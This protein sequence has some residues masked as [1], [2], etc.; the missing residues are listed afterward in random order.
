MECQFHTFHPRSSRPP[1]YP[2]PPDANNGC[3]GTHPG[4]TIT[5]I[6]S[7]IVNTIKK[8]SNKSRDR[9]L[10]FRQILQLSV[11]V[12]AAMQAMATNGGTTR[13]RISSSI[14]VMATMAIVAIMAVHGKRASMITPTRMIMVGL[15]TAILAAPRIILPH[16]VACIAAPTQRPH[17]VTGV[18][19]VR[20]KE[21][22][23]AQ[24]H[25][26]YHQ[27]RHP[28]SKTSARPRK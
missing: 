4:G 11:V 17:A 23:K 28:R 5:I 3:Q 1:L 26:T 27:H 18:T 6:T 13:G 15:F 12:I 14:T 21:I 8:T 16:R 9:T 19:A 2:I 7:I 20:R 24:H 22:L 25:H 10:I